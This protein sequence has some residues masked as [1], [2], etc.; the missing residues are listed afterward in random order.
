M[1]LF[2]AIAKRAS[3]RAFAPCRVSRKELEQ[4][5]DAG[6]RAPSGRNVQPCEFIVV[7]DPDTIKR[8]GEVQK[9]ISE[10]SAAIAVV[11]DENA[12]QYWKEDAAAAIEN[13]L[14]AAV[15]LGYSSLWVEGCVLM[16][17]DYAREVLGVPASKRLLA[18]LP[19]GKPASAPKQAGKKPLKDI[20][21]LNRYGQ[22]WE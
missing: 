3:V 6:R 20:V 16:R 19:I 17:E 22:P 11:V 8:L 2:D 4:I 18:I 14:L 7:C 15:A 10:A 21:Y 12:T 13:M 9:C 1:D 5:V